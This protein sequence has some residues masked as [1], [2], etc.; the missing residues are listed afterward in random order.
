M[1]R[2][3]KTKAAPG[4]MA[5]PIDMGV[6]PFLVAS[7]TVGV[8]AQR[9]VRRICEKCKVG[10]EPAPTALKQLNITAQG[11]VFTF[12]RGKGCRVCRNKGYRGRLALFELMTLED[13][14]RELVMTRRS[15]AE[16]RRHALKSGMKSL[17]HDGVLKAMR[18]LTTLEEVM[19]VTTE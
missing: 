4:A 14:L 15:T 6:E 10:Y 7:S 5:R 2:R 3:F 12:F 11:K 18:G 17:R 9:L 19:R 16:I 1:G 8:I 13:E